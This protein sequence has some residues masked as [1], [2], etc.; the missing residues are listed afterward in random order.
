MIA[1]KGLSQD[2]QEL[3]IGGVG[4]D[5][6]GLFGLIRTPCYSGRTQKNREQEAENKSQGLTKDPCWSK[7][8]KVS[9]EIIKTLRH[10]DSPRDCVVMLENQSK[11]QKLWV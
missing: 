10:R 8:L 9:L 2:G 11:K 5:G 4:R 3:L 1:K 6:Q 7:D